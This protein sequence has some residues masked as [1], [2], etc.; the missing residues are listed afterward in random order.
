MLSAYTVYTEFTN[1]CCRL[2]IS[3]EFCFKVCALGV[4]FVQKC[5]LQDVYTTVLRHCQSAVDQS[6]SIHQRCASV[7][8][9]W[10]Q[11]MCQ[12]WAIRIFTLWTR[13]SRL[14]GS[15]IVTHSWWGTCCQIS[16]SHCQITSHFSR[17]AHRA[18]ETINLLRRE[19]PDFI[20]PDLWPPIAEIWIRWITRSGGSCG[21]G[22][23][24][25]RLPVLTNSS[26][27]SL[28][29]GTRLISSWLTVP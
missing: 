9:S 2:L 25:A 1:Y 6:C 7:I 22:F 4:R 12:H 26:S 13:A 17:T 23:M 20:L 21:T 3:L 15:T 27:A 29:N 10:H 8:S 28:M 5:R 19:T 14:M 18:H 24:L 16:S 11:S